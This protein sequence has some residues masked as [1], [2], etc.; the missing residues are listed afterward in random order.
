[1]LDAL[2]N[3]FLLFPSVFCTLETVNQ[4]L[5]LINGRF[6]TISSHFFANYMNIFH[7]TEVQTIILTCWTSLYLKILNWFNLIQIF[8][9]SFFSILRCV[10]FPFCS[11]AVTFEPIRFQI[12][13]AP[14]NDSLN[15][16]FVENICTCSWQKN[17]K[18]YHIEVQANPKQIVQKK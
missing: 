2:I 11:S 15:F 7:K 5:Q 13:S 6:T 18:H 9:S 3:V 16:T 17:G 4:N 12:C 8:S 10:F 14:Q 1:M